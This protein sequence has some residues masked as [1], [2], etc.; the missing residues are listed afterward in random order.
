M[1][2]VLEKTPKPLRENPF[3]RGH[4]QRDNQDETI[5]SAGGDIEWRAPHGKRQAGE[6]LCRP[7][8]RV[9]TIVGKPSHIAFGHA[10]RA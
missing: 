8:G 7:D 2:V 1:P 4:V 5:P 3:L 6:P 10:L 9:Q